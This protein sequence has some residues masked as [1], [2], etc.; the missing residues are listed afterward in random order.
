[1]KALMPVI[2]LG[3]L[4]ALWFSMDG[5]ALGSKLFAI[6]LCTI[7]GVAANLSGRLSK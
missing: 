7:Y 5:L 3:C 2:G 4:V 1:M 6:F